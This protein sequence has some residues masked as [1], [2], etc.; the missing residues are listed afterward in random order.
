MSRPASTAPGSASPK[1]RWKARECPTHLGNR[2]HHRRTWLTD[3]LRSGVL[4]EVRRRHGGRGGGGARAIRER[5][6][7]L[8][9]LRG[10]RAVEQAG[11]Q[12]VEAEVERQGGAPGW[13][14]RMPLFMMAMTW[15]GARSWRDRLDA[16]AQPVHQ[17][18][19]AGKAG[20]D[21]LRPG[22]R[23]PRPRASPP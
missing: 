23:H 18:G 14:C 20:L 8:Q 17:R 4:I 1:R 11:I 19:E 5:L 3:S 9:E 10:D 16:R 15:A 21:G 7:G 12:E 13:S 22:H 6:A 2:R